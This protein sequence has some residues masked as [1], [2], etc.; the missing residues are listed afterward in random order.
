MSKVQRKLLAEIRPDLRSEWDENKN[1]ARGLSF[2]AISHKSNKKVWWI[3][4]R[5]H[6]YEQTVDKRT[7]RGYNCPYCSGKRVLPGV[8]DLN[9]THKELL[10]DWDYDENEIMP[11]EVTFGSQKRVSW[12]CHKCGHK[13]KATI[14]GRTL[15]RGCPTCAI[16]ENA[17]KSH[18]RQFKQGVNDLAT[19]RRDLL[20]E[21]NWNKN[22][23]D[24]PE[25]FSFGSNKKVWWKC[26]VCGHEWQAAINN[27]VT[28]NSGC[29]KCKRN[30]RTSFPEQAL[31]FYIKKIF[32][33]AENSYTDIFDVKLRELDIYIPELKTGIEYDGIAWHSDERAEKVDY[34]KYTTCQENDIRLIRVSEKPAGQKKTYDEFIYRDDSSEAG[35]NCV[36]IRTMSMLLKERQFDVDVTRDRSEIMKQYVVSL[37]NRSI[38]L[39]YPEKAKE[40][41]TEKNG[42]ITPEMVSATANVRYWWKC[43]YG[44]SYQSMPSNKLGGNQGCP[45]CSGKRLL[46]GFN[47]LETRYPEVAAEWDYDKNQPVLPSN[48][49]PGVQK[50]Y[51][52]IC[53]RG[54]SYQTSPNNRVY[55]RTGCPYCAGKSVLEGF[56]DLATTNQEALL[57]WDYDK[58][59][60]SPKMLSAGSGTTVWWKCN[61]GH[62]WRKQVATQIKYP[63]CPICENRELQ[64]GINDLATTKPELAKEWSL[65]KNTLRPIDVMSSFNRYVWWE[66][67]E[68]GTEWKQK[69]TVRVSKGSGC[70]KCGYS[71]K[72]QETRESNIVKNQRDLKSRFPEIAA[73]WDYEKNGD[74]DP[75]KI[76][77]GSNKKV[78]WRCAKGH[79]YM[80]WITDR[81]G[82]HRTGCPY[83]AGRKHKM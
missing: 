44:H 79:S 82:K 77:F 69:V 38:A 12:V 54:H 39:K 74:L 72:M 17:R 52:W 65:S 25:E 1:S 36:I 28:N 34:E 15:G 3:C 6:N 37:R 59:D 41:D 64:K 63:S 30:M 68:C 5:G 43:E 49:M 83:C 29:P 53:S 48:I 2:D 23:E 51:W 60:I 16:T 27:R 58:N 62:S 31:F 45:I 10:T 4:S 46:S 14:G 78:W 9:T 47:D 75:S 35:L 42:G 50:K 26:S 32:P 8:N 70:P 18:E 71:K 56:N 22:G 76:S 20:T 21:W 24:K 57:L 33:S 7:S 13:W 67:S 55:S 81:T 11:T 66:C 80:A 40:W 19:K 73:E 61:K